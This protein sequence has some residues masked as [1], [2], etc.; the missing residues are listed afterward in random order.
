MKAKRLIEDDT[1]DRLDAAVSNLSGYDLISTPD[2]A[3]YLATVY[4]E[5]S[6][7]AADFS[8]WYDVWYEGRVGFKDMPREKLIEQVEDLHEAE[9]VAPEVIKWLNN[10]LP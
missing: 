1:D 5:S 3:R 2:L 7:D 4:A 6:Q 8:D 10:N 9:N